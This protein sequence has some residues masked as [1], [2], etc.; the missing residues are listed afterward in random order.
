MQS[1]VTEN[2]PRRKMRRF[3][4]EETELERRG[5]KLTLDA[6]VTTAVTFSDAVVVGF[7]DGTIRFFQ[8]GISHSTIKA[9]KGVVLCMTTD[10]H[11]V[12]TGGDDGRFLSLQES[13]RF[14]GP[15]EYGNI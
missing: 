15:D 2:L 10:G 4:F 7:G 6:P 9:H 1:G 5:T 3:G 12:F 8:P 14:L 11:N 13:V